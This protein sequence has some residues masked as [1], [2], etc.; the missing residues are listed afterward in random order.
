MEKLHQELGQKGLAI[1]AID[2]R[3]N[4]KEV[5]DFFSKHKLTFTALLDLDGKVAELY[6]AWGLPVTVI[7]NKRGEIVGKVI[8][9]RDWHSKEAKEFFAK[10]LAEKQ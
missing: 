9:S 4:A 3:E 8:G 2:Y 6:Q 5:K 7:I 10:L 1:L